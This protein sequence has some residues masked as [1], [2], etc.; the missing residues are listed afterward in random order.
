MSKNEKNKKSIISKSQI[1]GP[2]KTDDK[3]K[4]RLIW[5][6][7]K[8]EVNNEKYYGDKKDQN[9][10]ISNT[11]SKIIDEFQDR[12]SVKPFSTLREGV[13]EL[14]TIKFQHCYIIVSGR[15]FQDYIDIMKEEGRNLKC[16]P[17]VF[18]FT[19]DS[20]SKSLNDRIIDKN[21]IYTRKETLNYVNDRF[22]N[23]GGV[24]SGMTKISSRINELEKQYDINVKNSDLYNKDKNIIF[25]NEILR[26]KDSN[27]KMFTFKIKKPEDLIFPSAYNKFISY[28]EK[29]K[30]T[31]KNFLN[32]IKNE[33]YCESTKKGQIF[34][35]DLIKPLINLIDVQNFPEEILIKYLT[36][37]YSLESDFY[38]D[39]N[40]YLT[41]KGKQGIY[42]AFISLMYRGLYLDVFAKNQ[43]YNT[44]TLY[45][46]QLMNKEE[47]NNIKNL[48]EKKNDNSL[49]S[50]ILFSNSFLSFTYNDKAYHKFL[51][52]DE[53]LVTILFVIENGADLDFST[54]ADLDGLSKYYNDER[55]ILFFPFSSFTI[56]NIEE[57]CNDYISKK[58]N[59]QEIKEN[60]VVTKIKLNYLGKYKNTIKKAIETVNIKEYMLN[61][62]ENDFY[63]EAIKFNVTEKIS[64]E[65]VIKIE[66]DLKEK[67]Q[68]TVETMQSSYQN[69]EY[70]N[71]LKNT[72]LSNIILIKS[73]KLIE[74][75]N[76]NFYAYSDKKNENFSLIIQNKDSEKNEIKDSKLKIEESITDEYSNSMINYIYELKDGRIV[77]CCFDNQI[78]IISKNYAYNK[79]YFEQRLKDHKNLITSI[80][81]L[82]NKKLCSCSFDGTIKLWKKNESNHYSQE[83]NLIIKTDSIFYTILEVNTINLKSY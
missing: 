20:F 64:N 26:I 48:F 17:N 24:Y 44:L 32:S 14:K 4:I 65:Q 80:I 83:D 57:N 72:L 81:E 37:I 42:E 75:N 58:K 29:N 49:P 7:E 12:F 61:V 82:S 55:E 71:K 54:L 31:I 13:N 74:N 69:E 21:D 50:E 9:K 56:E 15:Y 33:N 78:K 46:A 25:V 59:G 45:R 60:I 53:K 76:D 23:I 41:T 43:N 30:E 39:M 8:N 63:K 62:K 47:F 2:K 35:N 73:N 77:I 67:I 51:K 6:D 66:K 36:Y 1:V 38:K 34:I 28:E 16:V 27:Q 79:F 11:L 52:K 19:S 40:K 10:K 70:I 22:F 68:I 5:I 3:N 18:V